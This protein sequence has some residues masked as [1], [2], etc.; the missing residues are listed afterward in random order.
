MSKLIPTKISK[1]AQDI[2]TLR[3]T[4]DYVKIISY[5]KSKITNY[6]TD[7]TYLKDFSGF[8]GECMQKAHD[9]SFSFG[10]IN[11]AIAYKEL[12][13]DVSLIFNELVF[14]KLYDDFGQIGLDNAIYMQSIKHIIHNN[15]MRY[16]L[17]TLALIIC[18]DYIHEIE[19]EDFEKLLISLA[20]GFKVNRHTVDPDTNFWENLL[21]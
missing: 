18:R 20:Y 4:E 3:L 11:S 21:R 17:Y 7:S 9:Y 5:A 10:A 16:R 19:G 15:Y 1:P 12:Y 8:Y 2:K 14:S 6:D 13:K